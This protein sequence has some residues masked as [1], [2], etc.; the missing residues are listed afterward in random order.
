MAYFTVTAFYFLVNEIRPSEDRFDAN[1]F[2][3][4]VSVRMILLN[5]VW[6]SQ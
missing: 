4:T 3:N 5:A 1:L 2:A 6:F